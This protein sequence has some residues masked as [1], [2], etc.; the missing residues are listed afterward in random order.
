MCLNRLL[1]DPQSILA[2]AFRF[3]S[4]FFRSTWLCL[5]GQHRPIMFLKQL[6]TDPQLI[7]TLAFR[8]ARSFLQIPLALPSR[9]ASADHAFQ[10]PL[11]RH[12]IHFDFRLSVRQVFCSGPL[13]LASRPTSADH[14]FELPLRRHPIYFDFCLSVRQLFFSDPLGVAF[15]ASIHR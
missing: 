1:T 14:T 10:G 12:P 8:F 6:C 3:A 9:P 11:R 4:S 7:L 2:F 13:G 15:P 5:P